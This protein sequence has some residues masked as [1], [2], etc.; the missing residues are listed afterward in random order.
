MSDV[1]SLW[2]GTLEKYIGDAIFAVFG[3]PAAHEDDPE[4]AIRAALEMLERLAELNRTFEE[5]HGI[6]LA[7][8]IGIN[9]GEVIAPV[10]GCR[11]PAR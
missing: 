10:G 3:V 5:H 8:R 6:T 1:V 7:I 2:G 4:R 11:R 9:T